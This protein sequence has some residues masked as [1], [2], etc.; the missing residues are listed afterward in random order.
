M[1]WNISRE[2]EHPGVVNTLLQGEGLWVGFVPPTLLSQIYTDTI[3][4]S[5]NYLFPF[6]LDESSVWLLHSKVA[7]TC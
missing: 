6:N 5:V 2:G 4:I 7:G 1:H 3:S